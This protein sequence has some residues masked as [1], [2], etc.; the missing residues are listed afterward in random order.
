ME[1]ASG[2]IWIATDGGGLDQLNLKS[3]RF[4]H[5]LNNPLDQTS[6]SN[7]SVLSLAE[8]KQGNVWVGTWGGGLNKLDPATGTFTRFRKQPKLSQS[9][10]LAGNNIFRIEID[11]NGLLYIS[12]WQNGLQIF[13]PTTGQFKSYLNKGDNPYAI[14]NFSI[15]DILLDAD[16]TKVWLGGQNGLELFNPQTE[17]FTLIDLGKVYSINDIHKQGNNLLWLATTDGLIRYQLDSGSYK[18]YSDKNDLNNTFLVSIE[19][20]SNGYLWLGS[21][22]GLNRFDP[23]HETFKTYTKGD[24]LAGTGFNR[25]SHLKTRDGRMF[26][27]GSE[28]ITAFDPTNLPTNSTPP[29][30]HLTKFELY[31]TEVKPGDYPWFSRHID[32]IKKLELPYVQR[33]ISFEFTALNFISPTDNRYKYRLFGLEN[34]WVEV[35]SNR[36]RVRYTNLEPGEYQFQVMASNNDGIW[37]PKMKNITLIVLPPW[38]KLWWI[39]CL[40]ALF[41][42]GLIYLFIYWRLRLNIIREKYLKR[43]ISEK[44]AELNTLNGD[45]E[46]RVAQRTSELSIED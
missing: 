11:S 18:I 27:G 14:T 9:E 19:E 45:L 33:D 34:D 17:T 37:N 13:N 43:L 12:V 31:Q 36:R 3:G 25:F 24:G 35:G 42:A 40:F 32:Y 2:N 39:Q 46:R 10:T 26:F 15:N 41:A 4:T 30:V 22:N 29:S 44:T 23:I 38:W 5:Y 1:D 8:D 16:N 21:Q 20:D 28:G 7:D 6:L